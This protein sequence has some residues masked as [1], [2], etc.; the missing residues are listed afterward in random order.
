MSKPRFV[1]FAIIWIFSLPCLFG[2]KN[3][4]IKFKINGLKDTTCLLAYYY[5]NGTYIKD[6]LKV[7]RYGRCNYKAP[8]SLPKGLYALVISDKNYF[9]FVVNNDFKFSLETNVSDP[10]RNMVIKDSPENELFYQYLNFSREKFDQIQVF[11]YRMKQVGDQKDSSTLYTNK[12]DEINKELIAYKLGIV[13]NHPATLTALMI[14]VMKEPEIP[15]IPVLSNGRKDSTFAYRY[16][17]LHFWD[18]CDFT[19]DR[20]LRT[21]VFQNKLKKFYDNVVVQMPDTIIRESDVL[22]EKARSNPEMFKYLVWFTTYHYESSEIMGF[23]KIF[24]HI[25]DTYYITGQTSWITKETNEKIIKKANKIRPIL[26]GEKAPNMIMLDTNKQL[27][28]MHT[29]KANYLLILFWDPD[30]GHC[31]KE[32][33]VI[34]EFYDQN[35]DKYGMEIFAVCADTALVKWKSHI[36]KK[37]MNWINVDG[38]RA[39]T[40]DYHEL[41]DITS[42]PVIYLVDDQKRI[43]AKHLSA[44]KIGIFLENYSKQS[45]T[46]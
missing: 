25:V 18:D 35:K 37:K 34:K 5:S 7:D 31:E 39:V 3:Y 20:M 9:D 38:P 32:I 24:V 12:I 6:T 8:A 26:I 23:D 28:S 10:F 2:Q 4:S 40:A 36:R 41:Y 43:I 22:I 30:C 42:T 16:Y 21:P 17:K 14:N 45:K 1:L 33:P 15:E 19:D 27:V 44:E 46:K 11:Q 29:I 13:K